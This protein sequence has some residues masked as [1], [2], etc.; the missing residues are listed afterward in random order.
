[1]DRKVLLKEVVQFFYCDAGFCYV[2]FDLALPARFKKTEEEKLKK[3][4]SNFCIF[5]SKHKH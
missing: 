2:F 3:V 4:F 1:M 5:H